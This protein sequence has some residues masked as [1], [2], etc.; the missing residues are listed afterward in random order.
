MRED[1]RR[2]VLIQ[3]IDENVEEGLNEQLNLS[4]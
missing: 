1:M 3:M 2:S 4:F